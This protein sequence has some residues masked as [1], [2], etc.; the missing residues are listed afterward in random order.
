[1]IPKDVVSDP[2][3]EQFLRNFMPQAELSGVRTDIL[4]KYDCHKSPYNGNY[5]LCV[6]TLI[7]DSTFTC[8]TR[9]LYD[10][11]Q[12]KAYVMQ[13]SFP[14]GGP[15]NLPEALHGTDLIPT[16]ANSDTNLVTLLKLFGSLTPKEAKEAAHLIRGLKLN[17]Q[18]YLASYGVY[19]NPNTAKGFGAL[20]WDFAEG[21]GD[22]IQKVLKTRFALPSAHPYFEITEDAMNAKSSCDFWDDVAKNISSIM[23]RTG[24]KGSLVVQKPEL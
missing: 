5:R 7:R 16:F 19:G 1:M 4:K 10:A 22:K 20:R 8:N 21:T 3:F 14:A 11:Y 12:G 24:S 17:Y 23:K 9:N 15:L 6:S 18:K 13:Y 2:T